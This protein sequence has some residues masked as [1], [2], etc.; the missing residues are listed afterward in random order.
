MN[1][2]CFCLASPS[3]CGRREKGDIVCCSWQCCGVLGVIVPG[4]SIES[5]QL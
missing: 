4:V 2:S 3:A 1:L 5:Y